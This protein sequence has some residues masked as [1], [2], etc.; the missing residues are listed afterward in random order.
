MGSKG[1]ENVDLQVKDNILTIKIDLTQPGRWSRVGK[2]IV[3]A[4]SRGNYMVAPN[5]YLGLNFYRYPETD[6]E[7]EAANNH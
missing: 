5:R 6:E 2:K 4:S 7:R 1:L 3:I